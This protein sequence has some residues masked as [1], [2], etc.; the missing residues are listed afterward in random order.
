MPD[1]KFS[2]SNITGI[3]GQK[4][5]V[6]FKICHHNIHVD[7]Q[8]MKQIMHIF[9]KANV[10]IEHVHSGIDNILLFVPE[11]LLTEDILPTILGK[12]KEQ[13]DDV[14]IT[15]NV[16]LISVVGLGLLNDKSLEQKVVNV[17]YDSKF[18]ILSM[19]K[20]GDGISIIL[21]LPQQDF[22]LCV[23]DLHNKLLK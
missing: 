4:Y 6:A 19:N 7:L 22:E 14:S 1:N 23:N 11:K 12:L 8:S 5:Y 15:H 18:D 21:A 16:A 10:H 20:G 2:H 13:F 3:S 9:E 17:I